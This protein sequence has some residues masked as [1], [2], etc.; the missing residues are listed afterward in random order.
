MAAAGTRHRFFARPTPSTWFQDV[1]LEHASSRLP[2]PIQINEMAGG[3]LHHDGALIPCALCER[4]IV[5]QKT[6]AYLGPGHPV[7]GHWGLPD[8]AAVEGDDTAIDA[9][10]EATHDALARRIAKLI[11]L[12][13]R[14]RD[15]PALAIR[16]RLQTIHDDLAEIEANP[17][18]AES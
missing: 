8:P 12:P 3:A 18:G 13:L 16:Q 6:S 17:R 11:E 1:T 4:S 5:R 7:K 10:F 9:A 2:K 15:V 14:D